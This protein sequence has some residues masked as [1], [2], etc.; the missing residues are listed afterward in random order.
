MEELY[1]VVR[2]IEILGRMA[3]Q[4]VRMAPILGMKVSIRAMIFKS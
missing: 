3:A 1:R 2:K 4:E